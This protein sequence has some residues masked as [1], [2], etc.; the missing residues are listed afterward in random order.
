MIGHLASSHNHCHQ[1]A[2][3][4]P[5]FCTSSCQCPTQHS[6]PSANAPSPSQT[7][8]HIL[9][10]CPENL[11][12]LKA[13]FLLLYFIRITFAP[14][15]SFVNPW[16]QRLLSYSSHNWMSAS[17]IW[18][19]DLSSGASL[20]QPWGASLWGKGESVSLQWSFSI[21]SLSVCLNL[22]QSSVP[23]SRNIK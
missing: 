19:V 20:L 23:D 16:R 13:W 1:N 6:R 3:F 11:W 2:L 17:L 10:H 9:L 15:I 21:R 14:S 18:N 4:T 22:T 8:F 12:I 7:A 5:D